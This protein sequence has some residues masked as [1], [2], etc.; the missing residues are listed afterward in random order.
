MIINIWLLLTILMSDE[1]KQQRAELGLTPNI[2]ARSEARTID[3]CWSD[4][5]DWVNEP[6]PHITGV[7]GRYAGCAVEI[8]PQSDYP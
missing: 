8:L 7:T 2:S 1:V 3:E 5:H 6:L 4:A